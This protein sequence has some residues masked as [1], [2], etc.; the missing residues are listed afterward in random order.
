MALPLILLLGL[1][2][3]VLC[4]G[5]YSQ[6]SPSPGYY[7]SSRVPTTPF[8]REFRTLWGSQHQRKEQ[9]VITLWLDKSTGLFLSL[10]S[11]HLQPNLWAQFVGPRSI[12]R[13]LLYAIHF[14][15]K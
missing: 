14:N 8:D 3:L 1:A 12:R 7:P 9:D 10:S 4:P 2:L 5:G 6:R 13:K 15:E 11:S